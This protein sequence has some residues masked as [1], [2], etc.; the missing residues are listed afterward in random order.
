MQESSDFFP[1]QLPDLKIKS[2]AVVLAALM[3]LLPLFF[4]P[5]AIFPLQFSK[6]MLA[7]VALVAIVIIFS[8]RT[9][10]SGT[11]SIHWSG[12]SLAIA[13]LPL[14]YLISAI[15][16]SVPS[17]S[18]FGY[19]IDQDTFGF[20]A[21]AAVL[22][23]AI[24]VAATSEKRI[25][26]AL[27]GLL[28]GTG[29]L[30]LFQYVQI[31][32]GTPIH[33]GIFSSPIQNL[34]G[35]WNDVGLFAGLAASLSLLSLEV[36]PLTRVV[37]V[38]LALTLLASLALLVI[39]SFP[40]AWYLVG[41][42]AFMTLIFS[43]MRYHIASGGAQ[44][45][46]RGIVSCLVLAVVMFFVFFGSQVS[47]AVQNRLN[48]QAFEVS[49]SLQG[50][51]GVLENVYAKRPVVGSGPNTFSNEWLLYRPTEALSTVFWATEFSAGSGYIPTAFTTGGIVVGIGWLLLIGAFI[52]M[53]V[54]ALLTVKEVHDGSYFLMATTGLGALF[55]LVIHV[56]YVPSES[57]T[58]LLFIFL[59]LFM[60]S[61]SGTPVSRRLSVSFAQSP[62]LGFLSV[63]VIA[64]TLVV[65]VISLYA[66]G[67]IYASSVFAAQALVRAN[68]GDISGALSSAT[69]AIALSP[70]DRYYRTLTSLQL[71]Q[72]S[73]LVQSGLSDVKAQQTFQNGLS[74]AIAASRSAVD[75][76]PL[77][78]DNWMSRASVYASVVPLK[79]Q[80]A[81]NNA[82]IGFET[83]RELNPASPEVDYQEAALK[84]YAN[85]NEGA[86]KAALASIA[87]KADYTPAIL[88]LA[89]ASLNEGKIADAIS[90]L[91]SALV[92]TPSDSSLL[93]QLGLL[94]LQ[95][96]QYQDAAS[97]FT[98]ALSVT[99]N[100]ANASFYL[101]AAD[102]FLGKTHDAL[103][104]FK[105]LEEKNP[106]N[107]TLQDVIS[108]VAKGLNPFANTGTAALPP[109]GTL[110]APVQF[111]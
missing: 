87:K 52:F 48:I 42:V 76:D 50:T 44:K 13:T 43:V 23:L 102:V 24:S 58:L 99:P 88:L 14:T 95:A 110:P 84:V 51:L 75:L 77:S 9:L 11:L 111:Q 20:F 82:T 3:F 94:E 105:A 106:D 67:E 1:R 100:F 33:L 74:Q 69:E 35:K 49:P 103:A 72:L 93:Y 56:F 101:G 39:V 31:F 80:G 6:V 81:P 90:S 66:A 59:G 29:L 4:I 5:N 38:I 26:Y 97:S 83:A 73:A 70:Q 89:Q 7:L 17:L 2:D 21:L 37:L 46:A 71:A 64:I 10:R 28:L 79:I 98:Q 19:Q 63:L 65:S 40:F 18:F 62:R 16:S 54:R 91:K 12:L 85:D 47:V 57:L 45:K 78:Y 27:T 60:A 86:R 108:K 68:A 92:F 104:L 36:V 96:K 55:L 61:L 53:G 32:F 25:F 109:A 30:F 34:L 22:S 15:F 107:T 8:V 41:I